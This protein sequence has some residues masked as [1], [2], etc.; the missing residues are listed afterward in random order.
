MALAAQFLRSFSESMGLCDMIYI[1]RSTRPPSTSKSLGDD[2]DNHQKRQQSEL[3]DD[4]SESEFENDLDGFLDALPS[5]ASVSNSIQVDST[6]IIKAGKTGGD[7]S[8]S[9]TQVNPISEGQS[10]T[11]LVSL[12]KW[13]LIRS[14]DKCLLWFV[15][16]SWYI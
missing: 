15:V 14:R 10:G 12:G 2:D 16:S 9:V 5:E 4:E 1:D 6:D 7:Q 13:I 11:F 3:F 8:P